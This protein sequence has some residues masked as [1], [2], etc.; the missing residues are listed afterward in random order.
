MTGKVMHPYFLSPSISAKSL[1]VV[2]PNKNN[3]NIAPIY[4]ASDL[5][6]VIPADHPA[7]FSKVPRGMAIVIFAHIPNLFVR[8]GGAEYIYVDTAAIN[9]NQKHSCRPSGWTSHANHKE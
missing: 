4:H 7:I 1:V 6:I 2:A 5:N 3:P 8:K 9:A